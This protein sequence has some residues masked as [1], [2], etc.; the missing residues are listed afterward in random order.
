MIVMLLTCNDETLSSKLKGD[1]AYQ[2]QLQTAKARVRDN[3]KT[4]GV[5]TETN[6]ALFSLKTGLQTKPGVSRSH[7]CT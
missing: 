7:P 2:D 1:A 5:E 4:I 3:T 6:T